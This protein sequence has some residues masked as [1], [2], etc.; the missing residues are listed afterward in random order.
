MPSAPRMSLRQSTPPHGSTLSRRKLA[1]SGLR[2]TTVS[3]GLG[4]VLTMRVRCLFNGDHNDCR[5]DRQPDKCPRGRYRDEKQRCRVWAAK[6]N[7]VTRL[8]YQVERVNVVMVRLSPVLTTLKSGKSNSPVQK[9]SNAYT[10]IL[11]SHT[12]TNSCE[13][14]P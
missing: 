3:E 10:S 14:R 11:K 7:N 2:V 1:D 5:E 6:D 9:I 4:S 13:F 8:A 12:K